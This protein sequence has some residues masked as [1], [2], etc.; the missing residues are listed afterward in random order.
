MAALF[1][2]LRINGMTITQP[3]FT[4]M[5]R[6]I[7]STPVSAQ[8]GVVL[9]HMYS[10]C[11]DSLYIETT[12]KLA[13]NILNQPSSVVDS[14][15]SALDPENTVQF[16]SR[17]L[18]LKIFGQGGE[19]DRR[20]KLPELC[21]R[22]MTALKAQG[23]TKEAISDHFLELFCSREE[24]LPKA[25]NLYLADSILS[26]G[27]SSFSAA[28]LLECARRKEASEA[29]PTL[30]AQVIALKARVAELT[31]LVASQAE[32]IRR[33]EAALAGGAAETRSHEPAAG[34]AAARPQEPAASARPAIATLNSWCETDDGAPAT[35]HTLQ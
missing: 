9:A 16:I 12:T 26:Q 35:G 18:L 1:R 31:A 32:H 24:P 19:G 28:L 8:R 13:F 23:K 34:G 17:D 22:L 10:Y 29:S 2:A 3:T 7:E 33:L 30:E 20:E 5:L 11:R 6:H 15:F 4:L 21:Q 14:F 27:A 25:W